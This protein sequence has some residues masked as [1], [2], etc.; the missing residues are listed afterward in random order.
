[1][2]F[3]VH[4]KVEIFVKEKYAREIKQESGVHQSLY[5]CRIESGASSV[6]VSSTTLKTR[7]RHYT[8]TLHIRQTHKVE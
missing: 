5:I 8:H 1:M 3:K 4:F 2:Y 6:E 7:D